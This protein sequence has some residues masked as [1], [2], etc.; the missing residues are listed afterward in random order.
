MD[1]NPDTARW[2]NDRHQIVS[3][4]I[5]I[6]L[7]ILRIPILGVLGIFTQAEWLDIVYQIGT[8]LF[9]AVFLWWE[10]KNLETDLRRLNR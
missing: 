4:S 1:T 6:A 9:T 7:F 3:W 8:Y 5:I 2:N 10:C